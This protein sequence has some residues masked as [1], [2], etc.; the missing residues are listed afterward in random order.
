[1]TASEAGKIATILRDAALAGLRAGQ[2]QV[3]GNPAEAPARIV[4]WIDTTVMRRR[5]TFTFDTGAVLHLEAAGRRLVRL[6]DPA[7]SSLPPPQAALFGKALEPG[8]ADDVA[9]ILSAVCDGAD[10]V[11]VGSGV[12][13]DAAD[14]TETGLA[15]ASL[16]EALGPP[17][18]GATEDGR[19]ASFLDHAADDLPCA[20]RVAGDRAEA[21]WGGNE[22]LADLAERAAPVLD[23]LLDADTETSRTLAH[24]GLLCLSGPDDRALLVCVDVSG[25]VLTLAPAEAVG[26]LARAW[27]AAGG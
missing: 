17:R 19:L 9:A 10:H 4:E 5:L 2:P 3:L 20:M 22:D 8:D 1:M 14:P 7:P 6:M 24:G 15:T 25:F 12:I 16:S 26:R 23:L 21:F 18:N 27:A 13:P 11:T